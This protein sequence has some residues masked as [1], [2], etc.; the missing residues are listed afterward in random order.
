M[1]Y[2]LIFINVAAFIV[3]GID[4]RKAVKEKYRISE[5]AL[6]IFAAAGGSIGALLGMFVFHHKTKKPLFVIGVPAIL[7]LQII[8][9]IAI[10][11]M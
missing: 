3:F 4:K 11:K 2:W 10:K 6:L 7:I 5:K 1:F 9:V 8:I